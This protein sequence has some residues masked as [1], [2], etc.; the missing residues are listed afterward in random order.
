[1]QYINQ[2]KAKARSTRA[3]KKPSAPILTKEDEAFLQRVTSHPNEESASASGEQTEQI[4]KDA[5]VALMDG[6][7]DIPLPLSSPEETIE[8]SGGL[9]ADDE[10]VKGAE[11]KAPKAKGL[12]RFTWI[13]RE[14]RKVSQMYRLL[15]EFG[16]LI[17][18]VH[19]VGTEKRSC[20]R[21][22]CG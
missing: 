19:A 17:I 6:A 1:M 22:C 4:G 2:I 14:K 10:G 15:A 8:E 7:Q 20:G 9:H 21:K 13:K 12:N 16:K 11:E 18:N 5:Q 3:Q